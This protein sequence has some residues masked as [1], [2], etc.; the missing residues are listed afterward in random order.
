MGRQKMVPVEVLEREL[1]DELDL[2]DGDSIV[3]VS[4]PVRGTVTISIKK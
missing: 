1:A 3:S 4:G 2:D